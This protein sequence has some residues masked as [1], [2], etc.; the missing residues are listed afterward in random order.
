MDSPSLIRNQIKLKKF[1]TIWK[2]FTVFPISLRGNFNIPFK[3]L[4]SKKKR[5]RKTTI[6]FLQKIINIYFFKKLKPLTTYIRKIC[7]RVYISETPIAIDE[8]VVAYRERLKHAIKLPNKL[9]SEN[10]KV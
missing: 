3:F 10:Y 2:I 6:R 4:L 8:I 5:K 1:E 7:K 9:I